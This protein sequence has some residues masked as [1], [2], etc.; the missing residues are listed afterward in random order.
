MEDLAKQLKNITKEQIDQATKSIK[1]LLGDVDEGTSEMIDMM[2]NDITDELKK[3]DLSNGNPINNL[4]KIAECV[5]HKMMP[6]IDPNKVD[7]KKVW[8]STRNI[9]N[10]CHDKD[11]KPIFDGPNNPLS[12]ATNFLE[13]QMAYTQYNNNQSQQSNSNIK[14]MTE[15]DY[16]KECQ[17][18]LKQLG[19]PNISADQL[20]NLQLD[21]I[22][23]DMNSQDITNKSNTIKDNNSI[24]SNKSKC[25]THKK[26]R[27]YNI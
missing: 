20:K 13:K 2:L 4:T 5:A 6:K 27:P 10:K 12:M 1:S 24:K 23:Q 3:D 15:E 22:L 9:A 16:A 25:S 18:L 19:L 8:N 17:N 11:G 26:S 14:P 21:K 7:M